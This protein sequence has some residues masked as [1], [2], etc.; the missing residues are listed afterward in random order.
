MFTRHASLHFGCR[1]WKWNAA[2]HVH[3]KARHYFN[4]ILII[5]HRCGAFRG[6][7]VMYHAACRLAFSRLLAARCHTAVNSQCSNSAQKF[8]VSHIL[9][10]SLAWQYNVLIKRRCYIWHHMAGSACDSM[11]IVINVNCGKLCSLPRYFIEIRGRCAWWHVTEK[12][13]L[14]STCDVSVPWDFFPT[15][16]YTTKPTT[17][18]AGICDTSQICYHSHH[19]NTTAQADADNNNNSNNG[20][21]EWQWQWHQPNSTTTKPLMWHGCATSTANNHPWH[22]TT[23]LAAGIWYHILLLHWLLSIT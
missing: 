12:H 1:N 15:R 14:L 16:Q 23:P 8:M 20:N 11:F 6:N 18:V 7:I 4:I 21:E 3:M 17:N 5:V 13:E 22:T 10:T 19:H 9:N 2:K